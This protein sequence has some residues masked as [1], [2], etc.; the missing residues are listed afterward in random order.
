M[1]THSGSSPLTRGKLA[2][3]SLQRAFDGLIPAHAGKT[4]G[5]HARRRAQG[6]HP[7]SRGENSAAFGWINNSLGSSPLTRGKRD[8]PR[9][10][11]E[12][13]G[14][15][16][17]HAGKTVATPV[18]PIRPT[19]HPRSCVENYLA[20]CFDWGVMGS[21]PLTRGELA[22]DTQGVDVVG[23]I[24]THAG[25][26]SPERESYGWFRA[27]PRSCGENA[28]ADSEST[29][30]VGSSPLMRGKQD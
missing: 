13:L 11:V 21:S 12:A 5:T 23:L 16:P 7:R 14:L 15:I 25:K 18:R 29:V 27:H 6:A 3:E 24:P 28:S 20:A 8:V 4:H 17:A 1:E 26:T 22:C 19:A 30:C 10:Q 9:G 2:R